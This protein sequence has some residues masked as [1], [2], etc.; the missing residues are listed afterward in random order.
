ME[1]WTPAAAARLRNLARESGQTQQEIVERSGV[2]ISTY[3]RILK[4]APPTR[5]RLQAI[6]EAIGHS[7]DEVLVGSGGP[8]AGIVDVPIS[9]IQAS[10]GPGRFALDEDE[11]LGSWPMRV[12]WLISEG[13]SDVRNVRLVEVSGDSQEP[14]LRDGDKLLVDLGKR[15]LKDG[16]HLLRLGDALL[17]KRIAIDAGSV[18]LLSANKSYPEI[19]VDLSQADAEGF[20]VVAKAFGAIKGSM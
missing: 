4:G 5:D 11:T 3:Q 18:R 8:R 16:L 2:P 7:I 10:A 19:V 13:V 12:D 20:S 14:L 15:A 17:V 9:D 6:V 1:E